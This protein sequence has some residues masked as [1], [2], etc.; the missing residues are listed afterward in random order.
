LLL[1]APVAAAVLVLAGCEGERGPAGPAASA[2][3]LTCT[4]CHDSS[5]QITGKL[6]A[7]NQSK[8][9]TGEAFARGESGTC[10]PCHSGGA[11]VEMLAVG[12]DPSNY[13]V[14]DPNSTRQDCRTCH[15]L[16]TTYTEA[17]WALRTTDPVDLFAIDGAQYDAGLGNL[18]VNCHQPRRT[19]AAP[20]NGTI[21]ITS[22]HWGP[23]YGAQSSMLLGLGGAVEGSRSP[24]YGA[25]DGCVTCHLG[26]DRDHHYEASTDNCE[27]CHTADEAEERL[28][29]LE[30]EIDGLMEQL[31]AG[32]VERGAMDDEGHPVRTDD[33]PEALAAAVWNYRH[34]YQDHSHGVHNPAYT[35][36]LL[37]AS[38]AAVQ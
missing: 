9:G 23:H 8:H 35:R 16:H 26:E 3:D 20:E 14:G 2:S 25:A 7:W 6:A 34:I 24:H 30:P 33:V 19:L 29:A 17:D 32:L 37:E 27:P 10:S 1:A 28:E 13:G 18:C 4:Q 12:A 5:S 38:L 15:T 31:L 36:A 21:D 11:F 22:S